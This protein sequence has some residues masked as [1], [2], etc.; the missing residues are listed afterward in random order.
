MTQKSIAVIGAGL[1]GLA[2]A[3]RLRSQGHNVS[4]FE[5]NDYPG[6][7]LTA[8]TEQGYRFDMGPSLFTM[9]HFVE[10][11]FKVANKS[12]KDY[13]EYH[14]KSIVCNYFY[15]DG[16]RF[17]AYADKNKFATEASRT[18]NV[19]KKAIIG[20]LNK[21]KRKYDLTA[22]LF[23]EKSLHKL[24]TYL[25]TDTL[26][27]ILKINTLDLNTSLNEYNANVFSD[28]RLVQFF[29]R[30]AT[31]NGS[32]PY[33]T[34][35]IMSMIPHLEQHYGTFF[36]KGGMHSIT[37]SL[38]QL[39]KDIGV[40][41]NF[42]TKV[43]EII[44]N[45]RQV[46]GI[47]A[48]GAIVN[49]DIVVSN[50]DVVPTYRQLLKK[51]KAPEKVLQQPRSSSALIFYWGI[52]K[53][54]E[55]LDLH[56]IFF[57]KDYRTE[58]DQI[59]NKNTVYDDPTVYINITSKE[60]PNDAPEGC[61]N[62]FVM[63][64]VPSNKGQDWD[65]IIEYSRKNILTKLTR[66]LDVNLE[67]LIAYESILE[68]RTIESR[69]QS[70]QGALY[71]AASNNKFAAFLRHPNFKNSIKNLYFCGGSVHPGGGIPLCLLSGKIVADLIQKN[72]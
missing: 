38:Y 66:L 22:S 62:W 18:F 39:A 32:S 48:N 27:A 4:V 25:S 35:G 60:E 50:S 41:F 72:N 64:N 47:K 31:Y 33:Q 44:T 69:T 9:P 59:F 57:S 54:F 58:F 10:D 7:K 34:P 42:D 30:F 68:P 19:N 26:N 49:A 2:S 8:F 23:L 36:P 55:E 17:S 51:H 3:I 53:E 20:Y 6:G 5:A 46:T 1:A 14:Q 29:N 40:V 11:L 15:E 24:S 63:I 71:G 52:T 65:E 21:S 45:K 37:M 12:V 67:S 13:F 56:N 70:Y 43:E 28:E 61:E 16:T